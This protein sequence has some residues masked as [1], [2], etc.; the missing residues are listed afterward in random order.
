MFIKYSGIENFISRTLFTAFNNDS[1]ILIHIMRKLLN[2]NSFKIHNRSLSCHSNVYSL[3]WTIVIYLHMENESTKN[4]I[5]QSAVNIDC[6]MKLSKTNVDH[7]SY[8]KC[9]KT[10]RISLFILYLLFW[11]QHRFRNFW[12]DW[13]LDLSNNIPCL[14]KD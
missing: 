12:I 4:T 2:I 14:H 13:L 6:E 8:L 7:I 3:Q 5:L 1:R 9:L 11:I 10:I